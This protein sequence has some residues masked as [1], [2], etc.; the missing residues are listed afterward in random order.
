MARN[1]AACNGTR[2]VNV[3]CHFVRELHEKVGM[4]H[5]RE[6]GENEADMMTKNTTC[7]EFV[8]CSLKV[9]AEVPTNLLVKDKKQGGC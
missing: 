1:N 2:H 9:A 8:H 7:A 6:S 5:H 3:R 4:M